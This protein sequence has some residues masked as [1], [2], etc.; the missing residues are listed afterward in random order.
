VKYFI[1]TILIVYVYGALCLKYISGAKSFAFGLAYTIYD[2][3]D[4][5][6]EEK[7]ENL[8]GFDPYYLGIVI[9]AFFSIYFSFGNIENGKTLQVVTMILRFLVTG[10]MCIGS[11][12]DL[13]KFG[14]ER[15]PVFDW[16]TQL[17]YLAKVFGNTTFV[18]IYHHSISGIVYPVRPQKEVKGMLMWSNILGSIF[19]GTEAILAYFA[20]SGQTKVCVAK[21]GDSS[22]EIG[23]PCQISELYNE[24]FLNLNGIG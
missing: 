16:S 11:V 7:L 22:A 14:G 12:I 4:G 10:L 17:K 5:N 1:I 9:F 19:L 18:F 8:F 15:L 23:F 6:P 13:H 2:Y 3:N 24:N 21:E 20:F